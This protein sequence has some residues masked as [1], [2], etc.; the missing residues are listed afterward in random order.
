MIKIKIANIKTGTIFYKTF[1]TE[2]ERDKFIRKE[3]GR[4]NVKRK[5]GAV[6]RILCRGD[7][8]GAGYR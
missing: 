1:N 4:E 2:F 6:R 3:R 7:K 8:E 5:A